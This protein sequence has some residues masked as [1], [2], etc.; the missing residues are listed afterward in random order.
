MPPKLFSGPRGGNYVVDSKGGKIYI[1]ST[2][3]AWSYENGRWRLHLKDGTNML[4]PL[5]KA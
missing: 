5:L 1:P 4:F 3:S 2:A